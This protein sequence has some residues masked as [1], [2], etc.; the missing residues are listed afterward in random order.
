LVRVSAPADTCAERVRSRD[1][2]EHIPVSDERVREINRVAE[3]VRLAWDLEVDNAGQRSAEDVA[4]DLALALA[5][6]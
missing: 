3:G 5:L 2:A 6:L 4:R 1:A